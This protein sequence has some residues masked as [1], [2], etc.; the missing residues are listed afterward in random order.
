MDSV[1]ADGKH[2]HRDIV[3]LNRSYRLIENNKKTSNERLDH[4]YESEYQNLLSIYAS[5][6]GKPLS[7]SLYRI[8]HD[9][10]N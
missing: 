8:M 10:A 9:T 5:Q 6:P 2:K 7:V 1:K 3:R 4:C